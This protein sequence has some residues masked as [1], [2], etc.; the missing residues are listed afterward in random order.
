MGLR[1]CSTFAAKN[2]GYASV[3]TVPN[4]G[5]SSWTTVTYAR[6]YATVCT[7]SWFDS[8]LFISDTTHFVE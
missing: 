3:I 5:I 6:A 1:E 2:R 4:L 7:V 8:T